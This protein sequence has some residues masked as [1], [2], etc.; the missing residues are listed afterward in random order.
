VI[1]TA[2]VCAAAYG[3]HVLLDWLGR[4]D[5]RLAGPM[6][7]W[8]LTTVHLKSGLDLF[9]EFTLL[10]RRQHLDL[11]S[12]LTHNA[13]ALGRELLILG[14]PFLLAMRF[15][16]ARAEVVR[17]GTPS[18]APADRRDDPDALEPATTLCGQDE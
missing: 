5:S 4:D 6:A 8:P 3:S 16:L 17:A 18:G 12:V 14:P 11:V 2:T 13:Q 10:Y 15:R 7:T 9:L 1:R